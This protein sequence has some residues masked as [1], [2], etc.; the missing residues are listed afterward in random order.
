M[1]VRDEEIKRL[2]HYGQ[3]LGVKVT[4]LSGKDKDNDGYWALDGTEILICAGNHDSKTE[5]ILSLIHELGHHVW[6]IHEKDRQPDFKFEEAIDRELLKEEE[7]GN[8]TPKHLRKKIYNVERASAEYWYVI[9]KDTGIQIPEW[10]LF[11]QREYD[12]WMY[13]EYYE[14][15]EYPKGEQKRKKLKEIRKKWKTRI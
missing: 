12:V 10:K 7:K 14:K 11:A 3:G 6:F 4:I 13:E 15:G 2:I 9:Y 1:G 8:I 5:L